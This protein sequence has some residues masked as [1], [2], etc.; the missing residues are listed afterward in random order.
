M[1]VTVRRRAGVVVLELEGEFTYSGGSMARPLG[2]KGNRLEDL[3]GAL[4]GALREGQ[5]KILLDLSRVNFLD[6][7]GLGELVRCRKR[8]AEQGGD[9]KLLSP[10]GRVRGLL[11]LVH[12]SRIFEIYQDE[13]RAVRSFG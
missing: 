5:A 13:D 4:E 1:S 2:L 9:V 10:T 11:E 7:A 3:R 8:C 12:L 6:S